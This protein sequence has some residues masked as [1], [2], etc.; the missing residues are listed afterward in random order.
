METTRFL[1]LISLGLVLTMI[2]QAWVEDYGYINETSITSSIPE[3]AKKNNI[4]P[5][6]TTTPLLEIEKSSVPVVGGF[7]ETEKREKINVTTDVLDIVID[8]AGGTVEYVALNKYPVSKK[9]P[10]EKIVLLQ[11]NE[12]DGFYLMQ[13]GVLSK[14]S[15]ITP[16]TV[17]SAEENNYLLENNQSVSVPLY[18]TS[19]EGV[20]TKK[21]ITFYKG[22][23]VADVKYEIENRTQEDWVGRAYAEIVRTKQKERESKFI[24]TYTGA[25]IS[26]PE[27]RY[28]KISFGDIE[29]D[30][31]KI[32]T[33][34]GWVAMLQ[35][36]FLTAI[37]P[38]KKEETHTYYTRKGNNRSYIIGAATPTKEIMPGDRD[39]LTYR[40]YF[41]PKEQ[42]EIEKIAEGLSLTVDYGIFWFLAKPLY[43]LLDFINS[44]TNNWGWSIVLVTVILKLIFYRLSA[45]GYRSMANM[46]RVQPRLVALKERYQDDRAQLNKAM[47]DIYKKEKI[48]PLGGC[49]PILIQIPVFISLYWVLLESVELRQADFVLWIDDLS[50]ADPFFV[51]PLIMGV[52]MFVQQKLNPAPMDPIQAKVMSILPIVFTVFFAFFPA[53]LVL[54][55]VANNILSIVQQWAITRSIEKTS[56]HKPTK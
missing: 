43:W 23:Y 52:T 19:A 46:R 10:D 42:K 49:F 48:N 32:K 22:Q 7:S 8:T 36:Y 38:D 47:M 18:H 27:K 3:E 34:N 11:Q 40:I 6:Q 55:W 56:T 35:H 53:G 2:W 37:I 17:F 14:T 1:L 41:G 33:A 20:N 5:P 45:A 15:N 50:I 16:D 9:N 44:Y 31:L 54:Y 13:G 28:E 51:L 26:T 24:Y 29:D 39:V 21:T 30:D 12:Q 25:V 4:S